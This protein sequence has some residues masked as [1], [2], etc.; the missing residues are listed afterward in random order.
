VTRGDLV[1]NRKPLSAALYWGI[2][3]LVVPVGAFA[4]IYAAF[5]LAGPALDASSLNTWGDA[6][7]L[8]VPFWIGFGVLMVAGFAGAFWLRRRSRP[9]PPVPKPPA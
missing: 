5:L 4:I 8:V 7:G 2:A 1:A 9:N 3:L 6:E